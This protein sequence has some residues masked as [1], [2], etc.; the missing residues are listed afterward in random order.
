ML[1]VTQSSAIPSAPDD[2]QLEY[3]L[4][5]KQL[6]ANWNL[7]A[8]A[9]HCALGG[10]SRS[11][12]TFLIIRAIVMRAMKE[13]HSRHMIARFRFN[14]C[15]TAVGMDTIPKVMR[16]CFPDLPPADDMLD[17]TDWFYGLPNGSEIWITGLDDD[18]R[19]E[20]VLGHEYC[21]MF[22]NECSQI[23]W[24]SVET[25]LTRLAQKTDNLR[26][27]AY[28]DLN[29]P[30]KKHWTYTRFIEKRDPLTRQPLADEFDYNYMTLNP[31][32]NAENLDPAYL[33]QLDA[34]GERARKRF[35]YG[36]FADDSEGQ[37][38]TEELLAATRVLAQGDNPL[39]EMQRI[40]VAVDP[41]GAK[42]K[43][44]ERSDEIGITV[45]GLGTNGHGYLLEDL[46][47]KAKPE[48]WAVVV[49]EA[50]D[51]HNADRVVGEKNFGGDMVRAV[52]QA[53]N[54]DI[55]YKDVNA[56]HGKHI[57]AEPVS[58]LYEQGK[59]HHVGFFPELEDEQMA[60]LVSEYTGLRSPN[61]LDSLVMGATELFPKIAKSHKQ[62]QPAP[63]INTAPRS[64]RS[65]TQRHLPGSGVKVNKSPRATRRRL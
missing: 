8:D 33:R 1:T 31:A 11:G 60:M 56:S 59:Y 7:A 20:K 50:F 49:C 3:E 58:A 32:D 18:K 35:K 6:Q 62:H 37:L 16:L 5:Q 22:F 51:R 26:L 36:L 2:V 14:A 30:S 48:E 40:V 44:D 17:K 34:L 23:P 46:T 53:V 47:L 24:Q 9:T 4:T 10:G 61:R 29:P 63:N 19:T 12:K 57:R 45:N 28:Y 43:E 25:A 21:S 42:G 38:W 64:S 52:I 15:K 65:H 13:P 39:P 54:P 41:S 27:K 55:P